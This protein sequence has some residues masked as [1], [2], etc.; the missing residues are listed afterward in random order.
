MAHTDTAEQAT[1][2][3]VVLAF[4]GGLDTSYCVLELIRRGYRVVTVY[5]DTG[6]ADDAEVQA[7]EQRA[8]DLGA[9]RHHTLNAADD[10]WREFVIPLLYSG[11]RFQGQYPLLCSDRYVIVRRCLQL[12]DELGARLFAHGCTG[13]GNDQMRFDQTVRSLGDYQIIAPIRELQA[14]VRDVRGH[15]EQVLADA[16]FPVSATSKRYSVNENL[17]GVT[18]SGSEIDAYQAPAA[19]AWRLCQPR[20]NWPDGPLRVT[21]SF[22]AG[23]VTAIDGQALPGPALLASL[24]QQFGAYGVGKHIYTGDVT[25]GLKGRI[26]FECPGITALLTAAQAL[27]EVVST[28]YQNQF[29]HIIAARWAELVYS[30]FFYEPHKLD[31]EAYL[32]SAA[33]QAT[34]EVTLETQGG[35]VLA[36]AVDTPNLLQDP[37]AVYAQRASWTPQEAEGFIKL[38]GMSSTMAARVRRQ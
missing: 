15:E 30:G 18:W 35:Q 20:E 12:C 19:D 22:N 16:G 33:R 38:S 26:L 7:I 27:I 11:A 17:L 25:V 6:G 36:V 9:A 14:E 10:L 29:R 24:N 1:E 32:H 34:G 28:R 3:T 5:V 23:A 8:T 4:S 37:D 2:K 13:M 21:L 31:L